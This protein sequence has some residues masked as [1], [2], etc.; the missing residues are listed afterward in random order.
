M[1]FYFTI[2]I[3]IA[4]YTFFA[5]IKHTFIIFLALCIFIGI[6][7]N[8]TANAINQ[9]LTWLVRFNVGIL[10]LM[11]TRL[12]MQFAI[13][14]IAVTTPIFTVSNGALLVGDSLISSNWWVVIY[15]AVLCLLHETNSLFRTNKSYAI[16]II[17]TLIPCF[18]NFYSNQFLESRVLILI[19]A[20]F[21]DSFMHSVSPY[22]VIRDNYI[23]LRG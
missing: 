8:C 3:Y 7:Y 17:S 5:I 6:N 10:V 13:I 22:E 23:N 21:F 20:M 9:I 4:K 12:W 1:A 14:L 19:L 15:T 11:D 18:M 2:N 16:L